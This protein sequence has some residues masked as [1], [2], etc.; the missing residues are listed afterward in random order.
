MATDPKKLDEFLGTP[1]VP[2]WRRYLKW[3]AIG[4]G[5]VLL[6]LLGWRLFGASDDVNYATAAVERGNLT[7]TVSATGKLAP[8]NQV[9]VGSELSGLVISVTAD[10]NDR[11]TKGQ[12]IA[13]IALYLALGGGWDSNVTPTA[14]EQA[15]SNGN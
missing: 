10:V 13:L 5:V 7:V 14:P 11:V 1:A 12:A 8:N 4:V 9:T 3:I 2:W 15:R 6:V